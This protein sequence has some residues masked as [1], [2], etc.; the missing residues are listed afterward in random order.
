MVGQRQC[1]GAAGRHPAQPTT[2]QDVVELAVRILDREREVLGKRAITGDPRRPV[3]CQ[4]EVAHQD[5]RLRQRCQVPSNP[6]QLVS[7]PARDI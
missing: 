3:I 5:H 2:D 1:R 6:S 7:S 4:I